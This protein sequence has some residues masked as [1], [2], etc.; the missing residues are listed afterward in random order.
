MSESLFAVLLIL[1]FIIAM[2]YITFISP[3]VDK[4]REFLC[5]VTR[6]LFVGVYENCPMSVDAFATYECPKCKKRYQYDNYVH[7]FVNFNL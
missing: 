5:C 3:I 1:G 4:H 7:R 2:F 6:C